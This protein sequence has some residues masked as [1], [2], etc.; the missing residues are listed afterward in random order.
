MK[1]E[2]PQWI[3]E[4]AA[5]ALSGQLKHTQMGTMVKEKLKIKKTVDACENKFS[6]SDIY[7]IGGALLNFYESKSPGF[8]F[9]L[10]KFQGQSSTGTLR[11]FLDSKKLNCSVPGSEIMAVM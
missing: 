2:L 11:E 9:E 6:A 4:G 5:V 10:I 1:K 7:L 8:V 3:W